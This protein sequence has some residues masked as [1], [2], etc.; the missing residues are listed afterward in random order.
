MLDKLTY[1]GNRASLDGLPERPASL[2]RGRHLRPGPGRPAGRRSRHGRALRRRVAQRQL[3]AGPVAV[4]QR[5]TWSAPTHCWRRCAGTTPATTTSPPTRYTATSSST[6]RER[7]TETTPYNPSSPYS[8][9]K[10]GSDLLVRAWVRSFGVPATI[11]NCSNNY[12]PYQHVEK[13]IPRQITNV[14]DGGRPKLYGAG[15]NVR[16]WIHADDH[17]SAVLLIVE[18]GRIGETYLIGA[19]G[20]QNNRQVVETI[21]E[22]LGRPR[23]AL[24]SGRPIGRATTCATRSTRPSFAIELGWR[25]TLSPTSRTGWPT[26]STG[27]G[28]TSPGGGRRRPAPRRPYAARAS[29]TMSDSP[30]STT[31][32]PGLLVISLDIRVRQP[33]MVQGELATRAKWSIWGCRTSDRCR[34]TCRSTPALVLLAASTPSR[35]TS[36]SRSPAGRIFGAWVDL[37]PGTGFGRSVTLEMG[38][39]TAVFVPRG[40][41]N[42]F[43]TLETGPPTP[44]WSMI[45]GAWRL[46]DSYTFVNLA[47]E[48]WRSAGP[49]HS[50]RRSFRQRTKLIRDCL[51]VADGATEETDPRRQRP[52]RSGAGRRISRSGCRDPV[53][54][55]SE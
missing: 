51:V 3:A 50:P 11:S 8:S 38:P 4:R 7:F 55:R 43:Q 20:E 9:T 31:P 23:D 14:L 42:A 10:A 47:D 36:W 49:F 30:S 12:G 27:T 46:E 45:I 53:A 15:L 24:R 2:V 40:V 34:T 28:T 13:F 1:A 44:I 33:R 6:T 29:D 25:P 16:D 18:Q 21:L 26:P 5:P 19:D 17:S 35:G 41:G 54:A 39:E 37:R 32:I 22:L 48:T 52:A